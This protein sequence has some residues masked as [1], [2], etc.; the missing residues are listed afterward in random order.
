M[1][2]LHSCCSFASARI[3][4]RRA[5][6]YRRPNVDSSNGIEQVQLLDHQVDPLGS[7]HVLPLVR[8]TLPPA[9]GYFGGRPPF[10]I[11]TPGPRSR[12]SHAAA[13]PRAPPSTAGSAKSPTC[14][15]PPH[16]RPRRVR[17][18][19]PE[20]DRAVLVDVVGIAAGANR[21][22][23]QRRLLLR[24]ADRSPPLVDD[25]GNP[26]SAEDLVWNVGVG[27]YD[28]AA[29]ALEPSALVLH[30]RHG[31]LEALAA[32]RAH[33]SA[34]RTSSTSRTITMSRPS[35]RRRCGSDHAYDSSPSRIHASATSADAGSTRGL[36]R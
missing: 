19:R 1:R 33:A 17:E 28:R 7:D 15:S 9:L 6:S 22:E 16:G 34:S 35:R 31:R 2:R 32:A 30:R 26:E 12:L 13:I 29:E 10:R 23:V 20:A 21:L 14:G 8:D 27:D 24:R 4:S 25:V 18:H 5:S 36:G 11:R 3:G